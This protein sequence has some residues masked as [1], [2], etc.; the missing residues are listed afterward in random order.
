MDLRQVNSSAYT[1]I[2]EYKQPTNCLT[3][4]Y[5]TLATVT[6][7]IMSCICL[8]CCCGP[9]TVIDQGNEGVLTRFG[10]FKDI[11]TPGRY[12]Y[13]MCTDKI[14]QVS[15]K[16]KTVH[17]SKQSIM[18]RDNLSVKIDAVCFFKIHNSKKVLFN[19]DD[20][21]QSVTNLSKTVLRTLVGEN[22][23]KSLFSNRSEI[24][25]RISELL[26]ERSSDWGIDDITLDI[27]DV[28]IP[29]ELE[30]VMAKT[31]ETRQDA[32]SMVI[33]A[34]G[35]R[36]SAE[37]FAQAADLVKNNPEAMELLWFNTLKD[38]SKEKSNT[39]VVPNSIF[40]KFLQ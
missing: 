25:A 8:P 36:K 10:V 37:I 39:V 28:I 20:Y 1:E 13:N 14:I 18:T 15:K 40:S 21:E 24:N 5:N 3:C 32:E 29:E 33:S 19:V 7:N 6:G 2:T 12:T 23:L 31:A 4:V 35:E 9:I 38:I 26:R 34:E 16:T 30:R 27:K 17:I 11:L 22:T